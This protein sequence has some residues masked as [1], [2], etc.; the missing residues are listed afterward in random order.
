MR[1]RRESWTLDWRFGRARCCPWAACW[2]P[3]TFR[4]ANGRTVQPMYLA[5]WVDDPAMPTTCRPCCVSC[6]ANSLRA[7]RADGL[8]R[9]GWM[10][11][12][13]RDPGDDWE[14]G[15]SAN[16]PWSLIDA[17]AHQIRLGIDYPA[18]QRHRA[19]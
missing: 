5:P 7:V 6:G 15:Y 16:Q 12:R 8:S 2:D 9:R 10:A 18:D 1:P 17:D 4:L 13:R 19:V 3:V 11:G 14:H